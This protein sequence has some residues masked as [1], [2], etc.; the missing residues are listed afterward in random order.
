MYHLQTCVKDVLLTESSKKQYHNNDGL[1]ILLKEAG[2][3]SSL[4]DLLL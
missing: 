2:M 3:P 4:H 1:I